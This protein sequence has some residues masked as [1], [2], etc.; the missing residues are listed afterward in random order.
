MADFHCFYCFHKFFVTWYWLFLLMTRG[1]RSVYISLLLFNSKWLT[2]SPLTDD[3]VR[4]INTFVPFQSFVVWPVVDF[5]A[6]VLKGI[7]TN[8]FNR[9]PNMIW[10]FFRE[11]ESLVLKDSTKKGEK[12]VPCAN[13][14]LSQTEDLLLYSAYCI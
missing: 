11:L 12:G 3:F 2:L 4:M 8:D 1:L 6:I 7:F 9:C 13:R 10:N 5:D 14:I